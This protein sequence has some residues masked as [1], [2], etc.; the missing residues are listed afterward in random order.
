MDQSIHL[1]NQLKVSI[2][3]LFSFFDIEIL[4][5]FNRKN[6]KNSQIYTL[7]IPISLSK[8]VKNLPKNIMLDCALPSPRPNMLCTN[9][10]PTLFSCLKL[11]LHL[12]FFIQRILCEV[13]YRGCFK[14]PRT[15]AFIAI[16][17]KLHVLKFFR[18]QHYLNRIWFF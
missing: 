3:F 18:A 5:K 2:V 1:I 17:F 16:E 7:Q 15:L 8:N 14:R 12:L 13:P 4:V 9:V 6:R 11:A 10:E